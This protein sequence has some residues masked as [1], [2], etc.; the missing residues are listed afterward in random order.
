MVAPPTPPF[1]G[2]N[3]FY[4]G[5][6]LPI[7]FI[8]VHCT[9][10]PC[11]C[12]EATDIAHYFQR[13]DTS[14]HY[15]VD[16]CQTRQC[17]HDWDRAWHCGSPGNDHSIGVELCAYVPPHGSWGDREHEAMLARAAKLTAQLCEA[18]DV[19]KRKIGP[20]QLAA[21]AEGVCGHR[22][23]TRGLG[24][25][26]HTDPGS[27]FPWDHFMALVHGSTPEVDDVGHVDSISDKA[28]RDI[29]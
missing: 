11:T 3:N 24:G 4:S 20:G 26:T 27:A 6:N 17:V 19:P 25:T 15:V 2:T 29:A 23:V 16:S 21:G 8:V 18:Y 5:G 12:G 13:A 7:Q 10:S 1:I 22:D 14:A 28:A 9:I